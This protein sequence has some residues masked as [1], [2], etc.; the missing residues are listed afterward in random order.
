M[1][2]Q[3]MLQSVI[4]LAVSLIGLQVNAQGQSCNDKEDY[5]GLCEEEINF[6]S[7]LAQR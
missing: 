7:V 1:S 6:H 5:E 2:I 3:K 4:A